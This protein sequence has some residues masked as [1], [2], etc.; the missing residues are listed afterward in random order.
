MRHETV[1]QKHRS[2][3]PMQAGDC[4]FYTRIN[5]L[6]FAQTEEWTWESGARGKSFAQVFPTKSVKSRR[7]PGPEYV[8]CIY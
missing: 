5:K 7:L 4:N 6:A 1:S 3:Q 2:I 8:L